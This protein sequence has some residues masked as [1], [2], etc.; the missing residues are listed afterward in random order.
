MILIH[1]DTRVVV[2]GITGS[3]GAFHTRLMRE[4]GT[5]V[6]AGVTPGKGGQEVEGVPV[7]D[8]VAQAVELAGANA[9]VVF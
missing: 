7:Y 6:V 4:Y 9:S 3:A 2:Q 1:S 8:T 5:K